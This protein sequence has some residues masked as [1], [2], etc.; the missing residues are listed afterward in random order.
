MYIAHIRS[1]DGEIQT[2]RQHLTETCKLAEYIGKKINVQ[3]LAG[4]AGLLHDMGKYTTE[5][6]EYILAA[7]QNPDNPPKRGTVD[8]S[9]AGG[10]LLFELY[11]G[12]YNTVEDIMVEIVGNAILSHHGY[13]QDYI[14]PDLELKFLNRIKEKELKGYN[15]AK[16]NFFREV[17]TIEG[18]Q[19]YVLKAIEDLKNFISQ[20]NAGE[21]DSSIMFLTKYIFSALIDADRTSTRQFEENTQP[22]EARPHHLFE[23]YHKKLLQKIESFKRPDQESSPINRL[24]HDMSLQCEQVAERPSNIYSLS[25]PTG[26]GK[27]LASLRYALKHAILHHKKRVIYIVPFT[28]IIE[29]NAEEVRRILNDPSNILEHHSNVYRDRLPDKRAEAEDG[30]M[31]VSQK[32]LLAKDNWDAPVI[33]TTMVQ[34]LNVFY[35]SGTRNIRRL[36]NLSESVMI[37]DEVQKVPIKCIALYN[38]AV[39]FLKNHCHSSIVLCTAT[40][41]ALRDV[42]HNLQIGENAEMIGNIDQVIDH[43]SRVK[44]INQATSMKMSTDDLAEFVI[45]QANQFSSQLI[46]LNT[47]SVVKKLYQKLKETMTED[48]VF[49]LSTSMCAMHRKDILQKI[50]NKLMKRESIICVS[51]QLIE[52]GVDVSFQSVIRSL[53]GLDSIAQAAGRCNRHGE[54][55]K[56]LVYLIDHEEESLKWLPEINTGKKITNKILVDLSRDPNSH[57]GDLLSRQALEYFFKSFYK[58]MAYDLDYPIKSLAVKMTDLLINDRSKSDWYSAYTSKSGG[59][60]PIFSHGSFQTAAK[61]F[62]VIANQT[63]SI[64]VPYQDGK[65]V[66]ADINGNEKIEDW[67]LLFKQAQQYSVNVYDQEFSRLKDAG[68]IIAY[69]DGQL[70]S[71]DE[72]YYSRE[73]GIDLEGEA[74]RSEFIF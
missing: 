30:V 3:Y 58:E 63:T 45:E 72:S 28:T 17:L 20:I 40:Q 25:I 18:F 73:Y 43:F 66:I 51:T 23:D 36:H 39:N 67:S 41:P 10:R 57:G 4:L 49:H 29:Q 16:A 60:F 50:K 62:N 22:Q 5:F 27:T 13:L 46:I 21:V 53:S 31:N 33:F 26:G 69:F 68:A 35:A 64:L 1:N 14:T 32:L 71:L 38:Q 6:K 70:Y 7:V 56:G 54:F 12:K 74:E 19:S 8:H 9:T 55:E 15:E 52:A 24:R 42:K 34:F 37:F 48:G 59:K 2:V 65:E 61:Y 44:I 47:K 11:Y